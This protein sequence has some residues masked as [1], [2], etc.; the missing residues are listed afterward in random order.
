MARSKRPA[1]RINWGQ[2][3]DLEA[4]KKPKPDDTK[5]KPGAGIAAIG[6]PGLPALEDLCV[7]LLLRRTFAVR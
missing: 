7:P 2:R 5:P 1:V 3:E 6:I 4:S